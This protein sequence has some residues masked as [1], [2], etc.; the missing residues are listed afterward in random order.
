MRK[1]FAWLGM[2]TLSVLW[3]ATA[4]AQGTALKPYVVLVLDT[5]GSMGGATGSGPPSC[6]GTDTKLDH[7]RCAINNIANSYGDIVF[8]LGEF[9]SSHVTGGAGTCGL[10]TGAPTDCDMAQTGCTTTD[11]R[12]ELLTPL[13]DGNNASAARWT[14]QS[15]GT[16][17]TAIASDPEIWN[18]AGATPLEG[19]LKGAKRYYQGLQ[20]SDATVIWPAT[21]AGFDPINNDPTNAVFLNPTGVTNCDPSA[22][23]AG[24][25][26]CVSQCRPY[27]VILLTDGDETC[28]GTAATVSAAAAS[29]LS[30]T[31][32]NDTQAITT[33]N[34]TTNVVTI[35][36]AAAHTFLV[37]ETVVIAGVTNATFN[38]TFTV[39]AVPS[40]T[41]FRYAQVAANAAS[42]A[43]TASHV[44]FR[45]RYRITTKPIGF[46]IAPGY[47]PIE[48]IAHGGG[49]P[50]DGLAATHEGYYA[51]DEAG[52]E[53]AMSQI[54]AGSVR[55]EL[56]NNLD[57]DCDVK[58]DED[59]PNKGNACNNGSQGVCAVN[60][61]LICRADGT[62][63]TCN[64]GT[65]ACNAKPTGAACTVTNA[66]STSV[67][68]TCTAAG[69]CAPTPQSTCPVGK[70][71][72]PD[73]TETCADSLD[74]DCDGIV[75]EGCTPCIPQGEIC[76]NR[77]DNCNGQTDEGL[78]R[79]CGQGSCLGTEI[80]TAGVW[81]GCTAQ[82]STT[83]TCNG[84][85]DDCDGIVD[86]FSISCSDMITVGGPGTDN[87]G[88]PMHAPPPIPQN[89]CHPGT[90]T[91]PINSP[92]PHNY[93]ACS[94]E[95]KP[96]NGLAPCIDGCN[97][98]DD[99]CDN[100]I[101]EDFA[102]ANC[103]TNC[104]VGTTSCVNGVIM[105][106]A[107]PSTTDNTCNNID[108]DC[109]G[110]IDEDWV[111]NPSPT[112]TGNQCCACGTGTT[113]EQTK[114]ISGVPTC[115]TNPPITQES[116]NCL[117]D[118]CDGTTDESVTCPGGST[119]T[120]CQCAFPCSP[121]EF[122]CPLMKK[123]S[124]QGFC[125]N[126]PCYNVTCP[127]SA[128]GKQTCIENPPNTAQCV[129][130]CTTVTCPSPLVCVPSTGDCKPDDCSTFPDRCTAAQNCINGV[131][132]SNPCDGVTCAA[133]QYCVGGS[134]FSSC[135]DKVCPTG[136]RCR[137]GMC[138]ADPCGHA[139]PFG[140]VCNE[141]ATPPTCK[142]DPCQF[143]CPTGQ[144]C[145]PGHGACEDDP[146]V[147]THCPSPDQVCKGG[148]C[149]DPQQFLPDAGI[150]QHVTVG[151][152][153]CSTTGGSS[154]GLLVG[155][156]L[157]LTRRRRKGGAS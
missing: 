157:F 140:Q 7:A 3:S 107:V 80:C 26:C 95:T 133:D 27:I 93:S 22:A 17:G 132:V 87:P 81:G 15:C 145:N 70:T 73:N 102:P 48:D 5:S 150:E 131:C 46:G 151:G 117:D 6:G 99:D 34:R 134:C 78:T 90:K 38:G 35:T 51:A 2:A 143:P 115:V 98:V 74:N 68:G 61:A 155:L 141:N 14:D 60:G 37:G 67:A 55:S 49:A 31:P 50:D 32:R 12:F 62:G 100:L 110:I 10:N 85:D 66:N 21:S 149:Y 69:T 135:A 63:L 114:C 148:T 86:G 39:T 119:C 4:H 94:G 121:G 113:C 59:F 109:D 77:D 56:C 125:V 106:N 40:A 33:T 96:C 54:I 13:V 156:A 24:A 123:C 112:C 65:A 29:M 71:C 138:E 1:L 97:G 154:A 41:T 83:E 104:G 153:G 58:I 147:G 57:D 82:P 19:T 128:N 137:L 43:G 64:A 20:A 42:T 88:D 18:A 30:T 122:P 79:A 111:C 146:C 9:R 105:C 45:D 16:C 127:D 76:N 144:W 116:C 129:D 103:S 91:C 126:D 8:G 139:C 124:T 92:P 75:D 44:A 47:Q 152:G 101:D 142:D 36:T 118:D 120:N 89:I 72:S 25:N 11:E 52:L 108:D 84:L 53:I 23:C 136:Q 28:G 130:I